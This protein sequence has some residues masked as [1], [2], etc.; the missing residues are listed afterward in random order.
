MTKTIILCSSSPVKFS[1]HILFPAVL[2]QDNWQHMRGFVQAFLQHVG[3]RFGF[4]DE[5]V[6][7]RNRCFRMAGCHKFGD[8]S[9]IFRPGKPSSAL[10]Q[11]FGEVT[12]LRFTQE[13]PTALVLKSHRSARR[14]VRPRLTLMVYYAPSTPIKSTPLFLVLDAPTS[15]V[16]VHCKPFVTGAHS[17]V[18]Q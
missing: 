16:E 7:T 6:Y 15:D 2:F 13:K 12:G 3:G 9:R 5:S 4:V 8:P 14:S 17:I 18:S 10:V 1:K 11:A